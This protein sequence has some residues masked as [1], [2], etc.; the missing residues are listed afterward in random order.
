MSQEHTATV[1]AALATV[2]SK[3]TTAGATTSVV[4]WVLSSEFGFLV[5]IMMAIGGFGVNLYYK[6]K[7][8]KRQQLEHNIRLKESQHRAEYAERMRGLTR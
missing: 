7:E 3:F 6:R 4:S 5:G 8:D 2:G 1:D